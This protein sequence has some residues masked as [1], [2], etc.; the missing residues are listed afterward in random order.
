MRC[1]FQST[2]VHTSICENTKSR[3]S[4]AGC[5]LSAYVSDMPDLILN[6]LIREMGN[7]QYVSWGP[8]SRLYK[9][10]GILISVIPWFSGG[11]SL[12]QLYKLDMPV[13]ISFNMRVW[14]RYKL[15][16]NCLVETLVGQHP[17]VTLMGLQVMYWELHDKVLTCP[18]ISFILQYIITTIILT[19]VTFSQLKFQCPYPYIPY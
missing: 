8:A 2:A 12:W 17:L 1:S 9:H 19:L 18:R 3:Y 16:T 5:V 13:S 14:L 7:L 11:T 15:K 10:N 4:F 6:C